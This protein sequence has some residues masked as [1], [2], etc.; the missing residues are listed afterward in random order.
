LYGFNEKITDEFVIALL[1]FVHVFFAYFVHVLC[2]SVNSF[3]AHVQNTCNL[4]MP[5]N[6]ELFTFILYNFL[7]IYELFDVCY[8]FSILFVSF[9]VLNLASKNV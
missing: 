8:E 9:L 1:C 7:T 3:W 2:T 4:Y 6:I 5:Q